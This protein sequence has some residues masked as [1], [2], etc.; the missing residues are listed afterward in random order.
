MAIPTKNILIIAKSVPET[1]EL[2][3]K[4]STVGTLSIIGIACVN[5]TIAF[6]GRPAEAKEFFHGE[7]L[8]IDR[9]DSY[10]LPGFIDSHSH[11][12]AS[13][14]V[15]KS[16]DFRIKLNSPNK[17]DFLKFLRNENKKIKNKGLLRITGFDE[18]LN[19]N[20][21]YPSRHVLDIIAPDNPLQII[22]RTG[23]A[24]IL[25]S[26]AL[27]LCHINDFVY[28]PKG[29][30]FNRNLDT[31]SL[32]GYIIGMNDEID[33]FLINYS[34]PIDENNL[35]EW[36]HSQV[37]NG[38]TSIVHADFNSEL[39][40]WHYLSK[41]VK[42]NDTIPNIIMMESVKSIEGERFPKHDVGS[43]IKRGH[44]K[45]MV[46]EFESMI[47]DNLKELNELFHKCILEDRKVAIHS[48]TQNTL[49]IILNF[50]NTIDQK[51]IRR[52]EHVPIIESDVIKKIASAGV[53]IVAQ[54][55]MMTEANKKYEMVINQ[56]EL[57]NFHPWK[58]VLELNGFLAF[59]SDSP[60]TLSSPLQSIA[61]ASNLRPKNLNYE[62]RINIVDA[63]KAWTI[64]G[65]LANEMNFYGYI[66]KGF[67]A[68]IIVVK[69]E[70]LSNP[71]KCE[72][73]ASVISGKLVYS[74]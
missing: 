50:I 4:K 59:S 16:L 53:Y 63:I 5:D 56:N 71:E 54:P 28:E 38:I 29:V 33:N 64:S 34:N 74:C 47:E 21:W 70:I 52:I 51:I 12:F 19:D 2:T 30:F 9:S 43:R 32:D 62:Q 1:F 44:T 20:N 61:A 10:V 6:V 42:E 17:S 58:T 39:K 57:N 73:I 36:F 14:K 69:G 46:K 3:S 60:V 37:A 72:V 8:L 35:L 11:S 41:L 15:M 31:G 49:K 65:A 66:K 68:D 13:A 55:A 48:T 67:I 27:E 7:F 18:L 25:N 26:K 45:I 24:C 22:H 40:D 23:H